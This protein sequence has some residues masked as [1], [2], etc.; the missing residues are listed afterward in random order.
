[1]A[2]FYLKIKTN[3]MIL[4]NLNNQ[5]ELTIEGNFSS[6]RLLV[7][8]FYNAELQ[9][10]SLLN[11]HGFMKGI[12]KFFGRKH[13]V[14]IHPLDQSEGG[15]CSVEER[16]LLEMTHASFR[17]RAKKVVIHQSE[18]LLSD[19]EAKNMLNIG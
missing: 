15:L 1:M 13:R 3:Q 4:K 6:S 17:L 12:N 16:V 10:R 11:Q 5:R 7:G 8:D 19:I 14:L 18:H 2:D 9:L